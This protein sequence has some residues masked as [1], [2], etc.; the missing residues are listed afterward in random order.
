MKFGAL[1]S[2]IRPACLAPSAD[3][4]ERTI[5]SPRG[6]TCVGEAGAP[7]PA[8]EGD[9]LTVA[10]R[11]DG[12][13]RENSLDIRPPEKPQMGLWEALCRAEFP[14]SEKRAKGSPQ[15]L[16]AWGALSMSRL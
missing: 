13:S 16:S 9:A 2:K 5:A 14:P 12:F 3:G 8:P 1:F 6:A 15:T 11:Q 4:P 7:R 10:E